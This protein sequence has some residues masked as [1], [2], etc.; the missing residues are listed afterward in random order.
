MRTF[1]RSTPA[2]LTLVSFMLVTL[3]HLPVSAQQAPRAAT[4]VADILAKVSGDTLMDRLRELC[5][6]KLVR[7][8][9]GET[10][11][12]NRFDGRDSV[13]N[14]LAGDYLE[15]ELLRHGLL[16][17]SQRFQDRGRNIIGL[18]PGAAHPDIMYIICAH[19]DAALPRDPG[20]DDNGTGTAAVLEAA[21]LLSRHSFDYT[22]AY[23]FWDAEER[24]LVGSNDYAR[25]ARA[26]GDSII[27]VLNLD[28]I[29]YDSD[30]NSR[31]ALQY[32]L[33]IGL[34][35]VEKMLAVNDSFNLGLDL[36]V[37]LKST[38][39][40]DNY[41]FTKQA[42]P[43]FLLIEDW[44]DFTPHY[45]KA[46]DRP[47]T[48]NVT[49]FTRMTK[50]AIGALSLLAGLRDD[51]RVPL[52]IA[53]TAGQTG[54]SDPVVFVWTEE[55]G[56]DRYHLQ[57]ATDASFNS[58]VYESDMLGEATVTVAGLTPWT[59]HYWRVRAC[60]ADGCSRWSEFR[61]FRTM[62]G[63]PVMRSPLADE[64]PAYDAVAISWQP[65]DGARH[66]EL[67][68]SEFVNFGVLERDAQSLLDT[69]YVTGL[70]AGTT[71][72]VR[73][74][75]VSED[76]PGAWS[77]P[78]SF[79]TSTVADI[80][81][82]RGP[83]IPQL[84]TPSPHPFGDR[85]VLRF[86][87]PKASVAHIELQDLAGRRVMVLGEGWYESGHS[88]IQVDMSRLP[89]GVYLLTLRTPDGAH[90]KTVLHRERNN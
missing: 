43:S 19:Y 65:V 11:I 54:V 34:P 87:L 25:A 31:A 74:R 57:V 72:H 46:T 47:S 10:L 37:E 51:P 68:V 30:N 28:M 59:S 76:G 48:I 33:D 52:P 82:L 83:F 27:G 18:Q 66:Y 17:G 5:G 75:A 81:A 7:V 29:G 88:E 23:I 45:H 41:S 58:L 13:D 77:V 84:F 64:Q 6:E 69:T 9:G 63:A 49:F 55:E 1:L 73:V 38:T 40:S 20:A 53:P 36:Y 15:Q 56:A 62:V 32:N 2:V 22:I 79:T 78:T 89:G 67:Q 12:T 8:G 14:E 26:R 50:N 90:A 4:G 39:P 24:G 61:S 71:Y 3:H 86:S 60:G 42:Y 44:K 80:A 21:R 35:L 70:E 85:V 16:A